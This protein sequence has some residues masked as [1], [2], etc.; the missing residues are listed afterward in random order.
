M[1]IIYDTEEKQ[2][3]PTNSSNLLE[4]CLKNKIPISHSCEGMASC[5]T[6]RVIITQGEEKLP[7]RS[8][9]EKEMAQ[10]RKFNFQERLAC[11]LEVHAQSRFS[12][13]LPDE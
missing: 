11:Q 10:D 2:L 13:K 6:C 4:V 12:F 9:L 3:T 5:G 8:D 7:E 1:A